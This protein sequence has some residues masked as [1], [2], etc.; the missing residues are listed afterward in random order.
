MKTKK[1]LQIELPTKNDC[2]SNQMSP[3]RRQG[4]ARFTLIELLVVIA[5]IAILAAMLLPALQQSRERARAISCVSNMKQ[6]FLCLAMYANDNSFY[7][8]A[9]SNEPAD[10]QKNIWF[11]KLAPYLGAP[12]PSSADEQNRIRR[13]ATLRCPSMPKQGT[14][15]AS[16]AMNEYQNYETW[17]FRG[18]V[19]AKGVAAGPHWVRPDMRST[20]SDWSDNSKIPLLGDIWTNTDGASPAGI[21]GGLHFDD[22]RMVVDN[23]AD[24]SFRHGGGETKVVLWFDG[25]A[26]PVKRSA[27][28]VKTDGTNSDTYRYHCYYKDR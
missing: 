27:L 24:T 10:F 23:Y 19:Q 3:A 20:R 28:L 8:A 9:S 16:Y 26:S 21:Q 5:I 22:S 12:L 6:N 17:N 2:S 14:Y 7:P 1:R 25:T 13:M 11:V 18:I 4:K 15:S